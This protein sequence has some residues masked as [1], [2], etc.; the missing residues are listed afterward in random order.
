MTI[1]ENS[2]VGDLRTVE[3]EGV[4][5]LGSK[6]ALMPHILRA[7][8]HLPVRKV[9]DGFAG[10]TRV[11]QALADEG[12]SVCCNDTA[13]FSKVFAEC[14]LLNDRSREYY[15]P[16][17]EHLNNLA[18]T[19]GWFTEHYGGAANHGCSVQRDGRK[20][21][22]QIHNSM[23]LDTIRPEIDRIAE[24]PIERSV[25]LTSLMLAMDQV[26]NSVG[27]HA[28]YLRN[29][30]VRSYRTMSMSVPKFARHSEE[31]RVYHGDIFSLL[32][33]IE[34]DAAYYDPPYGSN[35]D[36]MPPSRVRYASYYHLWTTI[37]L[38]D[39]PK[40][41]GAAGR[42]EDVSDRLAAS[43][44]EEFRKNASGKY[45]VLDAISRLIEQ[46]PMKYTVMSYNNRGRISA[47]ELLELLSSHGQIISVLSIDYRRHVM[48]DMCWT[49]EW[50]V[51][52]TERNRELLIT[53]EK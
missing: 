48:S 53:I 34:A 12:Y 43:A 38:N 32:P 49:N 50:T 7:F 20:R 5:Y 24:D 19:S 14:Y 40:L 27:H 2:S 45:L 10:T 17:L 36:K 3:T 18:G 21:I 52:S 37:C 22:W 30:S 33:E 4:K 6:R 31:H 1:S 8:E 42:R 28:A 46:T 11:A 44:F 9:F 29:W 51:D 26:D 13:V 35:N 39:Q 23:K 25:L 15:L 41:V 16:L 47:D